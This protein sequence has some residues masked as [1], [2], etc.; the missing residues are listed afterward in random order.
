M[1]ARRLVKDASRRIRV[2]WVRRVPVSPSCCT[3]QTNGTTAGPFGRGTTHATQIVMLVD[4]NQRVI[5]M[6]DGRRLTL[7]LQ[8]DGS[9][10]N[11]TD[12]AV[13]G[14]ALTSPGGVPTL[15]WKDGSRWVFGVTLNSLSR[16][17]VR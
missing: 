11:L 16:P 1:R 12:A 6:G 17:P 8:P 13:Q 14:I 9:Y 3:Y 4:G 7:T 5:R 15:R 10:R 2:G